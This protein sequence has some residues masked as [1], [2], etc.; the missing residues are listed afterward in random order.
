MILRPLRHIIKLAA[1]AALTACHPIEEF[2]RNNRGDFE[3]LWTAVDEHY[4]FFG[5]KGID[6]Q[7]VHDRYSPM[8]GD[9][10]S[11]TQLFA[12]CASMLDELEDGHV[13]LSSGFQTS[14]YRKWW[15]DYPQN[16][17]LRTVQQR[18]FNFNYKQLGPVI[19]GLLPQ[20]VA[21]VHIPDFST[22]LSDSNVNWILAEM[23]SADGL[24]LDVRNNGGGSMSYAETWVRHF[25][26]EP[27]T[28][29]YMSHKTGPG[30]EDFS[31]PYP[32][33]FKPLPA[34]SIIWGKPVVVLTNRSTYS[35][36]N[37]LV[38]C[39][40]RLPNVIHSGATTGGG[41]G[42]PL[43]LELPGGW[44]V[45]MSAVRVYDAR[46]RLTEAGI[47]PDPGYESAITDSASDAMIDFAVKILQ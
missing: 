10:L 26:T 34:G 15:A 14:Y 19:Y 45:R 44:G 25:I 12:V 31:E 38:M 17:D 27:L 16:F 9:G 41:G 5:E 24:I 4:C 30:H 40:K 3:A 6:W 7:Q 2:E 1:L 20:N 42:M 47:A 37:Y 35:A 23:L 28:V 43:S 46:M 39:L 18:Y 21:Y 11:R 29:G 36:A 33:T 32:I 13:N 8:V 22:G